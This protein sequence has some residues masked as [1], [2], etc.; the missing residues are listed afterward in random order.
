VIT[1]AR[2]SFAQPR[3]DVA[4]PPGVDAAI[5]ACWGSADVVH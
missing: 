1:V 5:A 4:V 2:A 3:H